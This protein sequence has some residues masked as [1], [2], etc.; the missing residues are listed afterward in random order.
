MNDIGVPVH[1]VAAM[2]PILEGVPFEELVQS[3]EQLGQVEPL[4]FDGDVLLD[5][6]NRLLACRELG[7][8]P[9]RIQFSDLC[10][11]TRPDLWIVAK[12]IDRRHLTED[13]RAAIAAQ[14]EA[15]QLEQYAAKNKA[16]AQFQPGNKVNAE[17]AN[18]HTR[19]VRP[20]SDEPSTQRDHSAENARRTAGQIAEKAKVSRYKAEQALKLTKAAK[21]DPKAAAVAEKVRKGEVPL[22]KA[23][24]A[25]EPPKPSPVSRKPLRDRVAAK[26]TKLIESFAEGERHEVRRI[27]AE[28]CT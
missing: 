16:A 17:G 2:F 5:G 18:Q 26:L 1:P 27:L 4:V 14:A 23:V 6:R 9:K 20:N 19:T 28:L 13:Q 21:A 7:I 12:N 24:K 3:I 22:R 10:L 25:V 8:E 11:N 15:W